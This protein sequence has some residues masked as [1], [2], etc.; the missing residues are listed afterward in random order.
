MIPDT[1]GFSSESGNV[2]VACILTFMAGATVK[3]HNT[4]RCGSIK[5]AHS[6]FLALPP[7]G[8]LPFPYTLDLL[9]RI[10]SPP[11]VYYPAAR[12]LLL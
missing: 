10:C 9:T 1:A 7:V 8:N 4:T 2:S 5:T 6:R 12:N 11:G 3:M